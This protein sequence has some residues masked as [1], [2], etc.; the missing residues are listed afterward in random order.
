LFAVKIT[1]FSL[2]KQTGNLSMKHLS[3][4][5]VVALV[6]LCF[7]LARPASAQ[8]DA[9]LV[10]TPV[11]P[12]RIADTRV[13]GG[14]IAANVA[15][16]FD[17]TAVSNYS[18]Q[19]GESSNCNIGNAGSFAA[20]AANI[21][22]IN[23]NA[24][25]NLKSYAFATATP[26]TA[27]TMSYAAGEVRTVFAIVKLDQ[28]AASNEM[29]VISSASAHLTIDVVGYF[30]QAPSAPALQCVETAEASTTMAA[31][32]ADDAFAP[33][34]PSGY[35]QTA[36]NCRTSSYLTPLVWQANGACSARNNSASSATVRATRVCC[37]V[38]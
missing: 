28:S 23:P 26:V 20:L 15:R 17:V 12:C 32:A 7:A 21:T 2:K 37:R 4:V 18:F 30:T 31:G 29:S 9:N 13:A 6:T 33:N 22:V 14:I 24:S 5:Q 35:V 10:F 34:C 38:Q 16:A 25:G 1:S 27:N 36:T 11:A 3:L 19:G 8:V